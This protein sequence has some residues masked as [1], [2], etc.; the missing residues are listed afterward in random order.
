MLRDQAQA[1]MD[2]EVVFAEAAEWDVMDDP[3]IDPL[4]FGVGFMDHYAVGRADYG[5]YSPGTQQPTYPDELKPKP[6]DEF[7]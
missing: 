7:Q 3:R 1:D 4:V 5:A 2:D 6:I